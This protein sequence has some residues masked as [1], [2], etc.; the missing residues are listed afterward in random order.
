MSK[1]HGIFTRNFTNVFSNTVKSENVPE[2]EFDK[3]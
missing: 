2:F 1:R 3:L